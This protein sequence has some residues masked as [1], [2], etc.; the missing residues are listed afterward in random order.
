MVF[1]YSVQIL[2]G[3]IMCTQDITIYTQKHNNVHTK[4][5]QS[6]LES[7]TMCIRR[8]KSMKSNKENNALKDKN[9]TYKLIKKIIK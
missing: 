1:L 7:T 5:Q 4:A 3:T 6:A 9:K 8:D 2:E